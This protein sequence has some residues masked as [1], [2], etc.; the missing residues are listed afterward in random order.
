MKKRE[1]NWISDLKGWTWRLQEV[2]KMDL[3]RSSFIFSMQFKVKENVEIVVKLATSN[4]SARTVQ[5]TMVKIMET[6]TEPEQTFARTVSKRA[7][8]WRVASSSRRRKR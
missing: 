6:I 4:S 8:S 2:R 1:Q 3:G 7:M 5:T